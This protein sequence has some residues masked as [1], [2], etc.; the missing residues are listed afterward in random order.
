MERGLQPIPKKRGGCF[1]W[2]CLGVVSFF[3]VLILA[4]VLLVRGF[5]P[6]IEVN[7]K[8]ERVRILGGLIDVDGVKETVHLGGLINVTDD[9]SPT[10]T[11][12]FPVSN[13]TK[14]KLLCSGNVEVTQGDKN[15]VVAQAPAGTMDHLDVRVEDNTLIL[16]TK[17]NRMFRNNHLKFL[18]TLKDLTEALIDGSGDFYLNPLNTTRLD[19]KIDGAG[20]FHIEDLKVGVLSL[21]IDGAGDATV[22][23]QATEE[24]IVIDGAG[25]FKGLE[26]QA[27]NARVE[28]DGAG[29]AR[30]WVNQTL[31]VTVNGSG[32]VRYKG[33]PTVSKSIDGAGSVSKVD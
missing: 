2:G 16:D 28:I 10:I 30:L 9:D 11:K 24:I 4:I 18:V 12:E 13:F 7:E 6:L 21:R 26:L 25:D 15:S 33:S 29:D 5:F 27:E 23:G 19:L 20:D 8:N 1:K 17:P 3:L 31:N 14:I 22:S 32:D